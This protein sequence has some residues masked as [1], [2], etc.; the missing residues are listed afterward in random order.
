MKTITKI[1]RTV[2]FYPAV[3]LFFAAQSQAWAHAF[4][5]HA[6]P[7]VGSTVTTQPTEIKLWFT[8]NLEPAFSSFVVKDARGK[9]VDK[10]DAHLDASNNSLLIVSVPPLPNGTYTVTWHVTSVDTHRTQGHFKFTVKAGGGMGGMGNMQGMNMGGAESTKGP[11]STLKSYSASGVVEKLTPDRHTATINT[12]KIPD[13]MEAMTMDY[14]VPNTNEL[15]GIS[16][17]DKI[18]FTLVVSNDTDWIQGVHRTGHSNAGMTNSMPMQMNMSH[19]ATMTE[20]ND[21]DLLPNGAL[22]SEDGREIHFSDFR[23]EALAFTFFYTRC[24]LPNYCP[25]MNRNFAAA[26]KLIVSK[27]DAPTN[28]EF[29]SISFDPDSDTPQTLAAYGGYYRDGDPHHWLFASA[30]TN[31]LAVLAPALDLMVIREGASISHNL[32]TVVLDPRGRIYREFDGN[33]WTPEQLA[34]A[35]TQAARL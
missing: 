14:P 24:P 27:P 7:K 2:S 17:G 11:A 1:I 35:V 26:R 16:A 15:D 34:N 30:P 6:D 13:Y 29:L 9:E 8:Q 23:G 21:G 28:W 19:G 33:Q 32:R 3:I 12:D 5:D 4:L 18:S 31:T 25:L 20:L 22:T 10:K